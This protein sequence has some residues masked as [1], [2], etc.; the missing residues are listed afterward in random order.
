[1][2]PVR[3]ARPH[4]LEIVLDK[5]VTAGAQVRGLDDGGVDGF[6]IRLD[7]RPRSVDVV[8]L[9]YPGFPTDLQP[10]VI[11]LNAIADG[12]AMVTENVFEARF[13]P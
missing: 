13:T 12:T 1:M 3:G 10:M 5:P 2:S 11:A 7:Q 6:Q 8:T 9:P 4:H